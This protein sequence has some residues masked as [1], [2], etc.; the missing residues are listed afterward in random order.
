V[1]WIPQTATAAGPVLIGLD[2]EFGHKTSTSARAV[3]QG[4]EIAIEEINQAGGVLGGRQL[5]LVTRDN[6]SITAVG[7]DNL[8]ESPPARSGR[9]I[10]RQVQP[11]LRREPAG[12]P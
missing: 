11:D 10:R 1:F 6:R 8:R 4:I 2:A 7:L 9:G 12:G 5:K 3:Q